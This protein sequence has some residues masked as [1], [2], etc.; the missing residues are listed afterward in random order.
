MRR[1]QLATQ[2]ISKGLPPVVV[3]FVEKS[4][5]WLMLVSE[6]RIPRLAADSLSSIDKD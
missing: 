1:S 6:G 4:T 3:I 2:R 5:P